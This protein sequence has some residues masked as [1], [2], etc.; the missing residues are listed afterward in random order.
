MSTEHQPRM[1]VN[2]FATMKVDSDAGLPPTSRSVI[3]RNDG[4]IW[5]LEA[6]N[7]AMKRRTEYN[8]MLNP[9]GGS[10]PQRK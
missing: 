4:C 1:R 9:F 3:Y 7:G 10:I 8:N 5:S 2:S 6:M